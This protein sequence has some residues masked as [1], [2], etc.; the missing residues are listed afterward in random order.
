MIEP[1]GKA[2][3]VKFY[4]QGIMMK[5]IVKTEKEAKEIERMMIEDNVVDLRSYRYC[6]NEDKIFIIRK[7]NITPHLDFRRGSG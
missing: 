2:W 4:R 7:P 1:S 6:F 5:C 3:S